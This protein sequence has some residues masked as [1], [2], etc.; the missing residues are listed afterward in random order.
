MHG[1]RIEAR[2]A[3]L[4]MG[5]EFRVRLPR[6]LVRL[7]QG[8]GDA[9]AGAV[10]RAPTAGRRVLVADDNRD[11]A[12]SLGLLLECAGHEVW[13]AFSGQE[14]LALAVRER[15]EVLILDID[16][17]GMNGYEVA[18]HVRAEPWGK[19]AVLVAVTGWGQER[20]RQRAQTAGFDQH[21]TKPV[22]PALLEALLAQL[23]SEASRSESVATGGG[24]HPQ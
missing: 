24:P 1:G 20:D 22:D 8:E 9:F 15:P 7:A 4:G 16:M 6:S 14:A 5:S 12:D 2:S 23:V 11:A 21:L 18:E 3:G 17:P 19:R 13:R 10:Q